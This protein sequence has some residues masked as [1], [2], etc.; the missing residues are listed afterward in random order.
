MVDKFFFQKS[1]VEIIKDAM[2][3]VCND[4]SIQAFFNRAEN[5]HTQAKFEKTKLGLLGRPLKV[6]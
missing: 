2:Y 1:E 4:S 6:D 3:L 5:K